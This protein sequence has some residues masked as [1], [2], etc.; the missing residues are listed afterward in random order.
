M[1]IADD[2]AGGTEAATIHLSAAEVV[3][4]DASVS[5]GAEE[6]RLNSGYLGS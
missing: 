5:E 1:S 4:S 3:K 6:G 2:G